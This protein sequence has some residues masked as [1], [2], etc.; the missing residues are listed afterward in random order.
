MKVVRIDELTMSEWRNTPDGSGRAATETTPKTLGHRSTTKLGG[1]AYTKT[2]T[3]TQG[4]SFVTTSKSN[5][6]RIGRNRRRKFRKPETSRLRFSLLRWCIEDPRLPLSC[7]VRDEHK[8]TGLEVWDGRNRKN[9]NGEI[10]RDRV[11]PIG[12]FQASPASDEV[13]ERSARWFRVGLD[14]ERRR[15][16]PPV[17][18]TVGSG[19]R[20]CSGLSGL[21]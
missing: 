19:R 16:W 5:S 8:G 12:T 9:P 6:K 17:R 7:W 14:K 4:L 2:F 18:D 1:K 15:R 10:P 20:V 21:I 3:T 11:T 13:G